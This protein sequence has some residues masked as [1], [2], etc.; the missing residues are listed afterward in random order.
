MTREDAQLVLAAATHRRLR[1][2]TDSDLIIVGCCKGKRTGDDR[3]P[4]ADLYTSDLFRKRRA[5]AEAT[6]KP[7]LILSAL[8]GIVEPLEPIPPYDCTLSDLKC[9]QLAG[10]KWAIN[11]KL[12]RLSIAR[13]SLVEIH[14]GADYVALL[15]GDSYRQIILPLR[16][17]VPLAGLGI[18][19]QLA[20]YVAVLR[21]IGGHHGTQS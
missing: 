19:Q 16:F 21:L 15:K 4:A 3:V 14:A 18:G 5:Y 12:Q 11:R 13:N 8:H 7:W 20:E 1:L 10:L 6:G 2:G 17:R 9:H